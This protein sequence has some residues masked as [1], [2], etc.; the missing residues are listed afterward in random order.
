MLFCIIFTLI[1]VCNA[2][3]P[4]TNF[5]NFG[6]GSG[7]I[8]L[9]SNMSS[10]TVFVKPSFRFFGR[11]RDSF[12]V[13]AAG[14]NIHK[15]LLTA[16]FG[17]FD[18]T[19]G[20]IFFRLAKPETSTL[21]FTQLESLL[22][23]E[24]PNLHRLRLPMK[25]AA[26]MTFG[27][28][29]PA[30]N[31]ESCYDE[32][33]PGNTYQLVLTSN[34][35]FTF[36]IASYNHI[37]WVQKDS[38]AGGR[39]YDHVRNRNSRFTLYGGN[40][41]C[42]LDNG[43]KYEG[44]FVLRVDDSNIYPPG[45]MCPTQLNCKILP[46][47]WTNP[48]K[49]KADD[50]VPGAKS[51]CICENF[52]SMNQYATFL[53]CVGGQWK[54][55]VFHCHLFTKHHD[56][57]TD[58]FQFVCHKCDH[59]F[60][61]EYRLLRHE[62]K[63]GRESRSE[64]A[65]ENIRHQIRIYEMI[66]ESLKYN[67]TKNSGQWEC[68][69]KMDLQCHECDANIFATSF[70]SLDELI[71]HMISNHQAGPLDVF[72]FVCHKCDYKFGTE[73]RLLRHK[74]TCGRESRSAEDTAKIRYKFQM[75]ELLE[76]SLTYNMSKPQTAGMPTSYPSRTETTA[77]NPTQI[78][79]ASHKRVRRNEG[80]VNSA[81]ESSNL[82]LMEDAKKK[83]VTEE[84]VSRTGMPESSG[85][86]QRI[87]MTRYYVNE[88]GPHHVAYKRLH[89]SGSSYYKV[90]ECSG[91]EQTRQVR[92]RDVCLNDDGTQEERCLRRLT[93]EDLE[94]YRDLVTIGMRPEGHVDLPNL[95]TGTSNAQSMKLRAN[96][97]ETMPHSSSDNV[98]VQNYPI[99]LPA[100]MMDVTEETVS[101]T[102]VPESSG[103]NQRIPM[104]RYYENE[105]G[106][107]CVSYKRLVASG[108]CNY[109]VFEC[110]G[111]KQTKPGRN[112]DVCV[113]D[114][115]T[116]GEHGYCFVCLCQLVKEAFKDNSMGH[117]RGGG[118][119][120]SRCDNL[121]VIQERFLRRMP[122]DMEKYLRD[123]LKIGAQPERHAD[124]PN[125]HKG[126]SNAQSMKLRANPDETMPHS[127]SENVSVRNNQIKLPA[128]K[129][130]DPAQIPRFNN[131]KDL[132]ERMATL[133]SN[134]AS[135]TNKIQV[136]G[137][138]LHPM[139]ENARDH[140]REDLR[141]YFGQFGKIISVS[142][143]PIFDDMTTD[144]IVTFVHC[145]SAAKCIGQESHKILGQDFRVERGE[146]SKGE[147][148]KIKAYLEQ[149]LPHLPE[150]NDGPNYQSNLPEGLTNRIFVCG[151]CLH[152]E[153]VDPRGRQ[154]G[155]LRAYFGQF[156]AIVNIANQKTTVGVTKMKS[157]VAFE[158]CDSARQCLQQNTH[159]ICGQDFF[160]WAAT[161]TRGMKRRLEAILNQNVPGPSSGNVSTSQNVHDN[162]AAE[163]NPGSQWLECVKTEAARE[164]KKR[165]CRRP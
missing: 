43:E 112:L 69:N 108:S 79:N 68:F 146:P 17:K 37:G 19:K 75:Y 14:I 160:V 134:A 76:E 51:K 163:S 102:E 85:C 95:E 165:K 78:S 27:E 119:T 110:S 103:H 123:L 147:K 98:Y 63:C 60:G 162:P 80:N 45:T 66:E 149:N 127:S 46:P 32:Q 31:F 121:L 38:W 143:K 130:H 97:D 153:Q 151:P 164:K 28:V 105:I 74:E 111:C 62:E 152:P 12:N 144:A 7:D 118:L 47:N 161:P 36:F 52:A 61:T 145:K 128:D 96:P 56:G 81:G 53:T 15:G 136:Y 48:P 138:C 35:R 120:C 87:P 158:N 25:W 50:Y 24:F 124:F 6:P 30:G 65:L 154:S 26:V 18:E 159:K 116:Q 157:K 137:P 67:M 44:R 20:R 156:G 141:T 57:P 150:E 77:A 155:D 5:L 114:D 64:E 70:C 40:S 16:F 41:A 21:A 131:A 54:G 49:C 23:A 115:G 100:D 71:A 99:K 104:T 91:C 107:D 55:R 94:K 90:F 106:P 39:V 129:I 11:R 34:G 133:T 84:T 8:T 82:R 148:K 117:K 101:R 10:I 73:Y 132:E 58:V 86:N 59:K 92:S 13:S 1:C 125:L 2:S 89:G 88:I 42:D 3:I 33:L 135:F 4:L 122:K 93:K 9:T 126:T 140:Q 139:E 142:V 72:Q 109:K 29:Q 83:R 22:A 113:N